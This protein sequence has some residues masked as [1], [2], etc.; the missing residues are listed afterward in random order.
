MAELPLSY[1]ITQKSSVLVVTLSGSLTRDNQAA[2]EKCQ[3]E[4]LERRAAWVILHFRDVPD[5]A[6]Q[7]VLPS[8]AKL[9]KSV[10]DQGAQLR[11]AA[12]QPNLKK[13]LEE[14][15]ILRPDEFAENLPETL[16]RLAKAP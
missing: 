12:L 8:L 5:R 6:D 3:F 4:I 13:L 2:I 10:R 7:N 1:T 11:L 16:Q 15:G 9:Q 14:R